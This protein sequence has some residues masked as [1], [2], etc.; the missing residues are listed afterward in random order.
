MTDDTVLDRAEAFM[1]SGAR[2]LERRVFES[3]LPGGPNDTV[4]QALRA[5]RNADGGFGHALEPDLRTPASQPIFV[6]YGLSLLHRAGANDHRLVSGTCD[7]LA[8]VA[9][10][11]GAVPY[12][13]PDA[14]NFARAAHWNGEFAFAP[15]L[16]AT[17]GVAASLH[18]LAAVHT[19]LD[20]AT[21]WCLEEIAGEPKYSG[22]TILNVLE[23][24]RYLPDRERAEALWPHVTARIFESDHVLLELPLTGYGLTPLTFA[25]TPEAPARA[26]FDDSVIAAHLDYLLDQQQEDG[27]WPISWEPPGPAAVQEW[28]GRWTLDATMTLRAYGR[29]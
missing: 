19:W 20:R 12:A 14:R 27:G 29:L 7:F 4:V 18:A 1:W 17:A 28:R 13:L 22:H 23:L 15:S 21:A 8:Q 6:H 10:E 26:L 9:H 24:L 5:Y 16:H 2:L 25:P 3:A 11:S